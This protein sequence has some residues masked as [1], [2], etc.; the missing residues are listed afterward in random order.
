ML[1]RLFERAKS[2]FSPNVSP[3]PARSHH[4]AQEA[5]DVRASSVTALQQEVRKLQQEITDASVAGDNASSASSRKI[6]ESRLAELHSSLQLKQREL[7]KFQ[8]RI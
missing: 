6:D 7:A 5:R 3:P 8:A 1:N 2:Y 4:T